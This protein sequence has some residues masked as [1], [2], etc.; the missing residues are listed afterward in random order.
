MIP[1]PSIEE[2]L[3][4]GLKPSFHP[5]PHIDQ[6]ARLSYHLLTLENYTEVLKLFENDDSPFILADYKSE[7]ALIKYVEYQLG[8]ARTSSKYGG[9]DLLI[10]LKNTNESIG[11]INIY[12]L[13]RETFNEL[14][15][16][17]TFGINIE[18]KF[19][20]KYF[21]T[22]AINH[23]IEYYFFNM[24]K[25]IAMAYTRPENDAMIQCLKK[26]GFE[27]KTD[28]YVYKDKY[29]YFVKMKDDIVRNNT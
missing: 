17:F 7:S 1:I 26:I 24:G 25:Y 14:D 11:L 28:E 6:S 2:M 21:S 15:K 4:N 5:E 27:E 10:K 16:R 20:R 18:K 23:I 9:F 19:R 22:E 13:N 8:Y 3:V 29:R 12:D